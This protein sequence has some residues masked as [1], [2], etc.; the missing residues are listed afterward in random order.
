MDTITSS[1]AFRFF[2]RGSVAALKGSALR[3]AFAFLALATLLP[4][5]TRAAYAQATVTT[6]QADYPPGATA[7]ITGSGFWPNEV[8]TLQVTHA[9]ETPPGGAGHESWTVS[10][11]G[12]GA[13]SS[14]WYVDPDDSVGSVLLLTAVGADSGLIAQTTFTDLAIGL[15]DQCSNDDGDGYATGDTGCRWINGNLQGNNSTY[16]EGDATVQRLWLTDLV[17]GSSHTVT[18]KYGTTK[19]GK[20]A[21]DFLTTWDWSENWITVA[22]RCQDITG[23]TSASETALDIPEDPNVPNEIGRAHV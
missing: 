3:V 19:G 15:Y 8:V 1:R 23:C 11:D 9:D 16:F 6:D 17:P 20:H 22:D 13:F 2:R 10:A 14:S 12:D 18:L 5:A 21:Y 7:L 4:I